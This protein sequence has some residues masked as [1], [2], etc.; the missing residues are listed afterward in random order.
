MHIVE[1]S[2]HRWERCLS[3]RLEGFEHHVSIRHLSSP[4]RM[5]WSFMSSIVKRGGKSFVSVSVATSFELD[6]MS[7]AR[8]V[9]T[10]IATAWNTSGIM[11]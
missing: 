7:I 11:K 2:D 10:I 3:T 4:V 8:A 9:G 1:C 6:S 5:G